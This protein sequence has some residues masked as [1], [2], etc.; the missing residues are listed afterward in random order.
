MATRHLTHDTETAVLEVAKD[1]WLREVVPVTVP[2]ACILASRILTVAL[3]KYG[4][5]ANATQLDAVCWNDEGYRLRNDVVAS[6][7][8]KT[9]WSVGVMSKPSDQWITNEIAS[10]RNPFERDF[11]GHLVVETEHHFIDFT[12]GQFDR[13]QHGIVTGSPLIVPNS[14]LVE[15]KDGWKVPIIKGVYTIRDAKYPASPRNAPDWHTNY[16]RDAKRLID[17]LRPLLG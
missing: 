16:K 1:F 14:H 4:V 13:P 5:A 2:N 10:G 12:A 3:N 15:T 7:E 9:A 17:E 8:S 6:R 11:F